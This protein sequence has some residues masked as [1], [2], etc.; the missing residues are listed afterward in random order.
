MSLN[1]F[2]AKKL[3]EPASVH[4]NLYIYISTAPGGT[5]TELSTTRKVV[6]EN[7]EHDVLLQS[8][9]YSQKYTQMPTVHHKPWKTLA[10]M[11]QYLNCILYICESLEEHVDMDLLFRSWD[12]DVCDFFGL[13]TGRAGCKKSVR[14][15]PTYAFMSSMLCVNRYMRMS[16]V[17][18]FGRWT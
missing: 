18:Y 6:S 2:N 14:Q 5:N 10:V 8:T 16:S 1:Y 11:N 15:N 3:C 4:L 12:T 17:C 9:E 13:H 7:M